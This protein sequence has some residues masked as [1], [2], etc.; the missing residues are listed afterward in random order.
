MFPYKYM[1]SQRSGRPRTRLSSDIKPHRSY[2]V[3]ATPAVSKY[4]AAAAMLAPT[5]SLNSCSFN[6]ESLIRVVFWASC[7]W[8]NRRQMEMSVS[9]QCLDLFLYCLQKSSF[10]ETVSTF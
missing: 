2:A 8:K 5:C 1:Q 10:V 6:L 7:V 3:T 4:T 9:P